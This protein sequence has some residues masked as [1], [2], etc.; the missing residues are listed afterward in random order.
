MN[1]EKLSVKEAENEQIPITEI[2]EMVSRKRDS[3]DRIKIQ[4]R[5][6]FKQFLF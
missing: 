6:H 5:N 1:T 2:T 3:R 4:I